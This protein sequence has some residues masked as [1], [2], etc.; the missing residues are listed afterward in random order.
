MFD[1]A[2]V[3]ADFPIL[4]RTVH[5]K[6]LIYLDNAATTQRPRPVLETLQTFYT[7]YNANIH[8]SPHLLGQEATELYE[9]AHANVARFIGAAD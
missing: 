1:L 3:R 2:A 5:G 8:R 4:Q 6:P 7:T 9:Q